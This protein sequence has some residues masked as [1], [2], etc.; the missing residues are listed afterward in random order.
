M[1]KLMAA[2]PRIAFIRVAR[3]RDASAAL[4]RIH[5]RNG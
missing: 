1:A 2:R 5:G 4:E 3:A